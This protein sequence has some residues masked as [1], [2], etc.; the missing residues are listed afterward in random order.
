MSRS[1]VP[2][3]PG[4]NGDQAQLW[5]ELDVN[6]LWVHVLR[7]A[8]LDRMGVNGIAVYV[9]LKTYTSL[10]D[11][12][13]QAKVP[14][15]ANRLN[16]S[17]PTVERALKHLSELGLIERSRPTG[18]GA[19]RRQTQYTFKEKVWLRDRNSQ[20]AVGELHFGDYRPRETGQ[21]LEA[22]RAR[23]RAGQPLPPQVVINM[24]NVNVQ[25]GD[26]NVQNNVVIA[27]ASG[28]EISRE[29][30]AQIRGMLKLRNIDLPL[31]PSEE[32]L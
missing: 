16:I 31:G 7:G 30:I 19:D 14:E 18:P 8:P 25:V 11:G 27:P 29:A 24:Y 13:A 28:S 9:M 1:L 15:I 2:H 26:N 3:Q 5:D 6:L 21:Q 4:R 12:K 10:E 17:V 32:N 20:E 22:A 23:V